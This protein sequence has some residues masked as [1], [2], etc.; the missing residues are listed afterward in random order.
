MARENVPGN[1][2][3]GGWT[4]CHEAGRGGRKGKTPFSLVPLSI[5][6]LPVPLAPWMAPTTFHRGQSW[7]FISR[8][9]PIMEFF[10]FSSKNSSPAK[11]RKCFK[12]SLYKILCNNNTGVVRTASK[13]SNKYIFIILFFRNYSHGD[14]HKGRTFKLFFFFFPPQLFNNCFNSKLGKYYFHTRLLY[15][16]E[17]GEARMRQLIFIE[18]EMEKKFA[19]KL[20]F[21]FQFQFQFYFSIIKPLSA[22]LILPRNNISLANASNFHRISILLSSSPFS[23]QFNRIFRNISI[24]GSNRGRPLHERWA[25]EIKVSWATRRP[26]LHAYPFAIKNEISRVHERI[27]RGVNSNIDVYKL[28]FCRK[29][30]LAKNKNGKKYVRPSLSLSLFSFERTSNDHDTL[31]RREKPWKRASHPPPLSLPT[32]M[33][34]FRCSIPLSRYSISSAILWRG[35]N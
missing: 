3:H 4:L 34:K 16:Q 13:I 32:E 21:P 29:P 18:R 35:W 11:R 15:N 22:Q 8:Y 12:I 17:V 20:F 19:R 27:V 25:T 6:S 10:F 31:I 1:T 30:Y 28:L 23:F 14:T 33:E 2:F 9:Y 24:Y 7:W 5:L 26:I